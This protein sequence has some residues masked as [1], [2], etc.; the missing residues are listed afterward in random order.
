MIG[1]SAGKHEDEVNL[2]AVVD[3]LD[4]FVGVGAGMIEIEFNDVMQFI[5]SGK[6]GLL[7]SGELLDEVIQTFSNGFSLHGHNLPA[8][9]ISAMS[10]MYMNFD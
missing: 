6:D 1:L 7:H 3:G 5:L 4:E 8:I 9:G 2:V 10:R